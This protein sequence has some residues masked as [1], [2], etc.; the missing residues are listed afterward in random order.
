MDKQYSIKFFT[1]L[2]ESMQKVC[3]DFLDFEQAIDLSGYLCVEID[4]YRKERYVISELVHNTG[5]VISESYCTKAFKT[6]R[7]FPRE[8]SGRIENG[9]PRQCSSTNVGSGAGSAGIGR[10]SPGRAELSSSRNGPSS[11]N[12]AESNWT[13]GAGSQF[14]PSAGR[15]R[16]V[17]QSSLLDVK[18]GTYVSCVCLS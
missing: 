14:V 8:S 13:I 2:V 12:H 15:K 7:K 10:L 18:R 5:D 9:E 11:T 1:C 6:L 17:P 3:R 4:N 16:T